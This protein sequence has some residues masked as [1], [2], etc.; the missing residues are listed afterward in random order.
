VIRV[1]LNP[2]GTKVVGQSAFLELPLPIDLTFDAAGAMY[3]A[4]YSG[5]IF[6][7]DKAI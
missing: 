6:K 5:T 4:D 2:D 3:V 1:Q 7:V